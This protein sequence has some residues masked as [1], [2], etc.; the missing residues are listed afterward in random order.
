QA[1][2]PDFLLGEKIGV[3]LDAPRDLRRLLQKLRLRALGVGAELFADRAHLGAA[4]R[5]VGFVDR[6][7]D[8]RAAFFEISA[9]QR[10]DVLVDEEN[11]QQ[12]VDGREYE[13]GR[14]GGVVLLGLNGES[15]RGQA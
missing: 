14:R 5:L 9:R 15:G 11:K 2:E 13:L 4:L 12:E 6:R 10:Q 3:G 7:G 1:R 8:R